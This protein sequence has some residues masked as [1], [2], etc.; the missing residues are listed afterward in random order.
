MTPKIEDFLA[1]QRPETPFLVVDLDIVEENFLGLRNSL[2]VAQIFY[3]VKANPAPQLLARLAAE[4]RETLL[5]GPPQPPHPA[6]LQ[7]AGLPTR[8]LVWLRAD[9]VAERLWC[10][11]Q[12]LKARNGAALLAWLPQARPAQLRRLQVLA[13]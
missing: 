4:G 11:E 12:L 1:T 8:Q 6:G 7:A 3:A 2:P 13:R 9:T 5:V 10:T